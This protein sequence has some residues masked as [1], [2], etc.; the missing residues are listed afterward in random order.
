MPKWAKGWTVKS[1]SRQG[2]TYQVSLAEDG[3]TYGCS[4]PHW[5]YRLQEKGLDCKHIAEV[6]ARL[7][8]EGKDPLPPQP[9]VRLRQRA[10]RIERR[11][12]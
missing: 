4:C 2:Q 10:M 9:T 11:L 6:K 1:Q 3:T 8:E 12:A 5:L 7:A